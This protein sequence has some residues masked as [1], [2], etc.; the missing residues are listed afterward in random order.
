MAIGLPNPFPMGGPWSKIFKTHG[1]DPY[2][3]PM[4]KKYK[5][6]PKIS[7]FNFCK[8]MGHDNKYL[9]TMELMTEITLDTYRV[10]EEMMTGQDTPQFNQVPPPYN[11]VK[12]YY[13][14]AQPQYNNVKPQYN[15]T[16]YNQVPQYNAL[17]GDQGGYRGGGQGRGGFGQ[18]KGTI[19]FHNFQQPVHYARKCSL[20]LATCMYFRVG[21]HDTE[22]CLKLLGKIQEKRNQNNQNVQWISAE[23]GENGRNINIVTRGGSKIGTDEVK[24]DLVQHQWVNK[25]SEPQKKFDARK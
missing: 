15:P 21:D 6:V 14:N 16:Q 4:M 24:Q 3:F 7:Y 5:I 22:Y 23:S 11:N 9:R 13:N 12:K 20:P 1:N 25:N 8:S 2:H 10:Q 19:V 17:R 18:G